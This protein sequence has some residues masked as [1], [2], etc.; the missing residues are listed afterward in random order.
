MSDKVSKEMRRLVD[1]ITYHRNRYYQDNDPEISDAEYDALEAELRQLEQD[2]PQHIQ[3]DSP[4]WRVGSGQVEDHRVVPHAFPMLSLDNAYDDMEL[5]RFANRLCELQGEFPPLTVELKID[6]LS[7]STV[8]ERGILTRA[9]TRGDGLKG[10]DVTENARTIKDIPLRVHG[11]NSRERVEVRGEVY[12]ERA[13]FDRLN[14]GRLAR[15]DPPFANP[16]NAAAGSL[17]L[18][19]PKLAAQR[20]LRFFAYQ[21]MPPYVDEFE[22]HHDVL[23]A[24][25]REGFS[26][27]PHRIKVHDIQALIETR[28][29]LQALRQNLPYDID[30]MVIKVD[31]L[32]L[33]RTLGATAKHPRWALAFKFP[34]EQATTQVKDIHIQ[35]GRTGVLT[36]VAILEPVNLAG[37]TVSRATLHNY[38][39]IKKKDIRV[40]DWVFVEKGGDIIPKVVKVISQRRRGDEPPT[41]PPTQCPACD[42]RVESTPGQVALRCLNPGCPAQ[43]ERRILHFASRPALDIQGL[44]R[45]WVQQMTS[46]GILT[47]PAS[48][49][50]LSRE[51][52]RGLQRSGDKWATKLLKEID[53]SRSA[54]FAKVL[55]GLGIPMV[56]EKTAELLVEHFPTIEALAAASKNDIAGI[57][58]IGDTVAQNVVSTLNSPDMMQLIASLKEAGLNFEA[59]ASS[60]EKPLQGKTIVLTG[61][62][63]H[64]TRDQA[65]ARL[66]QLGASVS[67]SVSRNTD[68]VI[69]GTQAG[70]KLAKARQL[71]VEI[72]SEDW[73]ESWR[74]T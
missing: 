71:G 58:G 30:G 31:A 43:V 18:L 72:V 5:K 24:M 60:G 73:M 10:E 52:L 53:R 17:R 36:P 9:V 42:H 1:A 51:K 33:H 39:D 64:W 57:H 35:V 63:Q 25:A 54:P 46:H 8:Y 65:K 44:G 29:Q 49:Y 62:L 69:A 32:Q 12:M 67:S 68:L 47:D 6:G 13:V 26:V 61:S 41:K 59:E 20:Q 50:H 14:E 70:S 19:D 21:A 11:F 28:D 40:G 16:R 23:D 7:L 56:G 2:Y 4:T 15:E 3:P 27:N 55:F 37:S 48:I 22:S 38:D 66:K 45:E 74:E 34:A